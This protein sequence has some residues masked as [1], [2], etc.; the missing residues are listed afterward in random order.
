MR[1]MK[2]RVS[3]IGRGKL[4]KS[5]VFK[6]RKTKTVGGLKKSDLTRNKYGKIVSK[7]QSAQAKKGKSG[8]WAAS[9]VKARKALNVKGFCP[10]GG[11]SKRG[12]ELLKKAR[13]FY[14]A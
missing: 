14:K 10:V 11:K 12:Q 1:R 2:K 13:S 9:V 3:V 5:Q 7:K 6:G 4:A 8:K